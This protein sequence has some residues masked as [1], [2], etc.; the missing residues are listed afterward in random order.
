YQKM[1][2]LVFYTSENLHFR[3]GKLERRGNYLRVFV[4]NLVFPLEPSR[5]INLDE[6]LETTSH[7]KCFTLS[8]VIEN[9]GVIEFHMGISDHT[10]L[11][12][13]KILSGE[14][15]LKSRYCSE[16]FFHED[17]G[18][19]YLYNLFV[20]EENNHDRLYV[21]PYKK[22]QNCHNIGPI[23][24]PPEFWREITTPDF[25]EKVV[26]I[27]CTFSISKYFFKKF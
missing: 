10:I 16:I 13:K 4:A 20:Y 8:F 3:Y 22:Y 21:L 18:D 19:D 14:I 12:L 11:H 9:H 26:D 7:N 15:S 23:N 17:V 1:G 24:S 25:K 6:I 27:Y 5:L 2:S